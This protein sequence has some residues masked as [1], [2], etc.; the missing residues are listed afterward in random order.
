M[1]FA[2]IM[3]MPN[4]DC[5]MCVLRHAQWLVEYDGVCPSIPYYRRYHQMD[6]GT[7]TTAFFEATR[8]GMG[9]LWP[10]FEVYGIALQ[11][12]H[13]TI[14]PVLSPVN[15]ITMK[16]RVTSMSLVLF[17][18]PCLRCNM[19]LT[20]EQIPMA[21]KYMPLVRIFQP[22]TWRKNNANGPNEQR[23]GADVRTRWFST[24][25]LL[26]NRSGTS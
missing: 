6:S 13:G 10:F 17:Q 22:W 20:L 25:G 19:M 26:G 16:L 4:D 1:P 9:T 12:V 24:W 15:R 18:Q 21:W 23:L 8:T 3:L 7:L 14:L 5:R 11:H 2:L